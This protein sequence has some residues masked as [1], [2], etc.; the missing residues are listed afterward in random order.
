MDPLASDMDDLFRKAGESYPLRTDHPDWDYLLGKLDTYAGEGLP[1]TLATT[2]R[3]AKSYR[4]FFWLMVLVPLGWLYIKNNHTIRPIRA[5]QTV[6][7]PAKSSLNLVLPARAPGGYPSPDSFNIQSRSSAST[8]QESS[9]SSLPHG[10]TSTRSVLPSRELPI[11]QEPRAENWRDKQGGPA[12]L[13]NAALGSGRLVEK[14]NYVNPML[15]PGL[16]RSMIIQESSQSTASLGQHENRLQVSTIDPARAHVLGSSSD[17]SRP[18]PLGPGAALASDHKAGSNQHSTTRGF[19]AGLLAAPDIS[20]VNSQTVKS[21][22]YGVGLLAGYQLTKNLAIESG[23]YVDRKQYYT[24]GKYFD[25][26]RTMIASGDTLLDMNGNCTMLEIPLN[27]QYSF[28]LSRRGHFFLGSGLSTYIMK[29]ESYAY[30]ATQYGALWSSTVTYS[31]SGNYF[32]AILN[33]SAG[34]TL[35]WNKH[36]SFR[37]EPYV[38]VPVHGVGIGNLEISSY[39]AYFGLIYSFKK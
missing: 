10:K 17:S 36:L 20:S 34:Y 21:P 29:R 4:R 27:L 8:A 33:V 35:Q 15:W 39:G 7:C 30:T 13:S 32:M 23:L 14:S 6:A 9:L 37:V 2:E 19:Y 11:G 25:K 5:T 38:K 16:D 24:E 28:A 18:G 3:K 26:S 12:G 31:N 22:G 1:G